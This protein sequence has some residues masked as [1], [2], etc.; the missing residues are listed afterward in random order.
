MTMQYIVQYKSLEVSQAECWVHWE[1]CKTAD[2]CIALAKEL[3]AKKVSPS[4]RAV[5]QIEV[6][7]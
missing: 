2:E 7:L 1:Y 5:M 4:Y 6:V 3:N